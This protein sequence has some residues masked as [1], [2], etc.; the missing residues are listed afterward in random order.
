MSKKAKDEPTLLLTEKLRAHLKRPLGQLF[1]DIATAVEHLRKLR[2]TRLTT[3]G[4]F[5]TAKFIGAGVKPDVAVVDFLV[6]REPVTEDIKELINSLDVKV[7]HVKNPAGT[8]TPEMREVF[9][10]AKPPLKIIVDGEEDL[11]TIPAVLSA[12][13]GSVVVYGQP[14]GGVV[15]VKVTESKRREF[16]DL[17]KEFKAAY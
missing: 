5:V 16:A 17:L 1:P 14:S 9:A 3:V 15:L 2:P 7:V 12:P 11:A 6:T 13:Q 8:I 4:D 10:S